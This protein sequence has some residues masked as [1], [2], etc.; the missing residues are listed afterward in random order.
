MITIHTWVNN[1]FLN[2][3][4]AD[5]LII[6]TSTG[7]TAYAMSV[8]GP[9][10]VPQASNFIITPIAPHSLNMRPIVVPDEWE[11]KFSVDSRNNHFLVSLDGRSLTLDDKT[12]LIIKKADFTTKT[13][14]REDHD[15]FDPLRN[16]LMWGNDNRTEK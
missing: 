8:G 1:R 7:S 15:F 12:E 13:I 10:V 2:S 4:Q 3:Y 11:I 16:K 6:A 14:C 9:I 5:G